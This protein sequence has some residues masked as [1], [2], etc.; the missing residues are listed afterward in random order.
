MY[1]PLLFLAVSL[2]TLIFNS[3]NYI[4]INN[5]IKQGSLSIQILYCISWTKESQLAKVL[6]EGKTYME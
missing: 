2:K 3:K 1:N 6:A 4:Y 5:W